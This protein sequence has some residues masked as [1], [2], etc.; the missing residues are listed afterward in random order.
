MTNR[1]SLSQMILR[2]ESRRGRRNVRDR[3][4]REYIRDNPQ[5]KVDPEMEIDESKIPEGTTV[6]AIRGVARHY[7]KQAT[8][9]DIL[10]EI[11]NDNTKR[12]ETT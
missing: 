1:S 8:I 9:R 12:T 4:A 7:N 5:I 3:L 11:T 6:G 2:E 10:R